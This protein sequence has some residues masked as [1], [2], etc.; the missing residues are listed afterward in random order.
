MKNT[1]EKVIPMQTET[2]P[3]KVTPFDH[4][5]RAFAFT[6]DNFGVYTGNIKSPG[7]ALLMEMGCGKSLVGIAIAGCLNQY[8]KAKR[9]LIVAPLSILGVWEEEFA[10]FAD[11]PYELVV[12]KGTGVKKAEALNHFET[13]TMQVAVVNY[14]SAWRILDALLA[15][16]PDLIIADEA[17]KLKDGTS[18]QS[19]GMHKLG[20]AAKYK[21]LLTGTLI[22]NRELDVYSQYRFA[23]SSIFGKN[24]ILFRNHYFEMGGYECHTPI[25]RESRRTEFLQNIHSIAFRVTKA[26]CLDLPSITEEVRTVELEPAAMRIYKDLEKES[27]AELS[28]TSE[29]SAANILTKLLRLSQLCG[30]HLTDDAGNHTVVSK[31]KLEATEDILDSVLA[32]GKKLVIMARFVAELD[33]IQTLLEKKHIGYAVVRGGVKD[34]QSEIDRFQ[35]DDDCK[36]FV[37]QIAAA[38]LGITLTAASTMLF[39][40]MDYSM[41]NF[42]QA[43]ARIHRPCL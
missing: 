38:G 40:S 28:E 37:G 23:D 9:V 34:R 6:C 33:D 20:D 16:K 27:F 10:K 39:Y 30:G 42:E 1:K 24:F 18:R 13:D 41:S 26:E 14:E 5:K 4:Q 2:M 31:A 21:L 15:W 12:L 25:F 36:V 43:K 7:T 22:S 17:H 32:E 29:V 19:K 35:N 11:F 3:V 8:S